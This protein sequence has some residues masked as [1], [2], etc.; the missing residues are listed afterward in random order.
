M[1]SALYDLGREAFL[2][3]SISWS[4]D[5]I[6]VA[7]VGTGYSANMLTDQFYS[8]VSGSAIG[9]PMTLTSKTTALGVADAAD[10]T[11]GTIS[12][13]STITQLVIYKDTGT[14][15]TSPLISRMDVTSTPTNGGTITVSWDNS[16]SKIF[17]L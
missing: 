3:G 14:N 1:A 6:K 12:T 10:V 5:T 8:T 11:S 2:A 4:S 16:S 15:S 7:L 9:T 13:G 17:K